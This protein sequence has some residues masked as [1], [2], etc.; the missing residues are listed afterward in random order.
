MLS[1]LSDNFS[2]RIALSGSV[3][4]SDYL[5]HFDFYD[6]N[7]DLIYSQE[8][9]VQ[10]NQ[11]GSNIPCTLDLSSLLHGSYTMKVYFTGFAGNNRIISNVLTHNMIRYKEGGDP[12]LGILI[13]DNCEQYTEIPINYLLVYGDSVKE[14]N[15][16]MT[17]DDDE[18]TTET[19]AS[20][21]LGTYNLMVE[22]A[23]V[24]HL[25]FIIEELS[26]LIDYELKITPY[27]GLLPVI[28]A[29]RDDLM[30]YLSPR[31]RTNNSADKDVWSGRSKTDKE[32]G[33]K[34]KLT[35]FHYRTVDGWLRDENNVDYLKVSQGASVEFTDFSPFSQN[36][37]ENGV[38]V[39]LDF[40][41]MGVSNYNV[42]LIDCISYTVNGDI[43]TGFRVTGDKFYY[44]VNGTAVTALNLV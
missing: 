23:N 36:P 30:V 31:G 41:I 20:G 1:A 38:T 8:S 28:N 7:G 3:A 29:T 32:N 16:T 12:I 15:L 27:N 2:Y 19:V 11:I 25:K 33:Y 40:M 44:Y 10:K 4:L 39:E 5:T 26:I 13:P 21:I 17:L 24:Y 6:S 42:P 35:G 22:Q 43:N 9:D 34:A 18:I 14:Y 37:N